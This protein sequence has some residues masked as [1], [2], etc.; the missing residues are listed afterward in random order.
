MVKRINNN[1]I[2]ELHVPGLNIVKNFYSKLGFKL[3]I[4]DEISKNELGYVTMARVDSLG[5]TLLSFYGGDDRVYDQS[6]FKQF[7]NDTKRGYGVEITIPVEDVEGLYNSISTEL[8]NHIVRELAELQDHEFKWKDFRI[9]DPFGF[10][11]RFTELLD[12]GQE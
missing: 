12:W 10:Y 9:E 7:S 8:K 4:D 3:I 2:I 6:Y 1:L 5:S 11:I